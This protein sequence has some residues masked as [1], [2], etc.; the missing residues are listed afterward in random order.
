[1][2]ISMQGNWTVTVKAKNAAFPQ[3]FV[4]S[5]ATSG[6]GP[7]PGTPGTSVAVTGSQWTIAVQNAPGTGVQLSDT[8]LKFPRKVGTRYEFDIQSNDA[9][10]DA[11]FDDLTLTCS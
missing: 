3:R 9:G 2:I 11:D 7:H 10:G 4:I 8:L 5:G 1:M 6:N